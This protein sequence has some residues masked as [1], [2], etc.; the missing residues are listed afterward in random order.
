[1]R[2]LLLVT[3]FNSLTQAVYTRL[4]DRGDEVVVAY[5]ISESQMLE[6]IE[7]FAPELILCP[8]LKAYLPPS[9][10]ENYPTF[11]F[12]PGPKGD[13]GP[14]ALEHALKSRTKEWGV[15]ILRAN[16]AYDG[17]DIY[18]E[19]HFFVRDTYKASLYRQEVLHASLQALDQFFMHYEKEICQPQLLNPLHHQ[20]TQKE[21]AIDWESD[22]TQTIV[23]KIYFSDSHP[24]VLDEILGVP[25][26]L[27]G[28]WREEKFGDATLVARGTEVPIPKTVLA[29]RDGAICIK[30]IDGAVWIS[31]LKE[32]GRF[33][34]PATY[35]LKERMQGVKEERLPLIF[36]RSYETFHEVW[37]ERKDEVAYLHFNFHNG[38]MSAAQCV[39]LKYAVEYLQNE[40]EVLVL[41]GGEDFF[42][43]GI[44]LNIL[45]DS[46]KQGEDGWANIN[47]MN[48]LVRAILFAEEVITIA[49][50]HRNAGAGGVFLGLACDYVVG[51]EGVVLNPHYKTLG[52]TGSEYHTYSLPKRVGKERAQALLDDCLPLSTLYAKKIGMLDEVF[53]TQGYEEKLHAYVLSKIDD[54]F[55][56]E[57]QDFL[58]EHAER[59]EACKEAEIE[60]MYPEF[61]EEDSPFHQLRLE[62]VYKVCPRETPKRLRYRSRDFS[63]VR[64]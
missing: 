49:S 5:A 61:W 17:G 31:H 24:G 7:A 19:Q 56:W 15:V 51:R 37:M 9:I 33:K 11:I 62:F 23:E 34:L 8:F 63:R 12:H 55:L 18:A 20:F 40:C 53:E 21:R 30:T 42:S 27:Y 16:E 28:A 60:V 59:I 58:E 52:L 47:A 36:D 10:Y 4:K 2:I 6:E 39:R 1:M 64:D 3:T 14:H 57:K 22:D 54:D 48:D 38:A 44:H 43:N 29:K 13:R 50:F 26:Y 32:P 35:V 25:C 41:M 45:E 46:Q